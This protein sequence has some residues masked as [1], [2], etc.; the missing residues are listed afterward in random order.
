MVL[1]KA[2]RPLN[3]YQYMYKISRPHADWC[4]FRYQ[5]NTVRI[6]RESPCG[7]AAAVMRFGGK[8]YYQV[9]SRA[10]IG[11]KQYDASGS[12]TTTTQT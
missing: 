8:V 10:A 2:V 12:Y 3:I 4:E 7:V 1:L 6:S 11:G 5:L 9:D